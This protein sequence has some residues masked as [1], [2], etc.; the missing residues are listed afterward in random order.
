VRSKAYFS[1]SRRSKDR[2]KAARIIIGSVATL[3]I[4]FVVLPGAL[5]PGRHPSQDQNTTTTTMS[6]SDI[7]S[8]YEAV[9]SEYNVALVSSNAVIATASADITTQEVRIQNDAKDYNYNESGNGCSG[10]AG[11]FDAC[12][13]D[14]QQTAQ[15]ALGD[16]NAATRAAKADVTKQLRSIQQIETAITAFVQQ[17]DGITWPSS[18]SPVPSNMTHALSDERSTYVQV[19]ADLASGKSISAD[20]Q[21]IAAAMSAVATP[22]INMASALGI[23]PPLLPSP[24]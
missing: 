11:S 20:S 19:A 9:L 4:V 5:G 16:E 15:I 10:N 1:P 21:T 13:T 12:I 23:P 22:F 14:E 18:V 7:Q 2:Q 24:S 17:V 6:L 3:A 8:T